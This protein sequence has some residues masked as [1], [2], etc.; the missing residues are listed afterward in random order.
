MKRFLIALGLLAWPLFGQLNVLSNSY[1]LYPSSFGANASAS[2]CTLNEVSANDQCAF[3]FRVPAT[4]DL[5][6]VGWRT[7]TV[8][9]SQSLTIRLETVDADTGEPTGTLYHANATV[10]RPSVVGSTEYDETYSAFTGTQGDVVALVIYFTSTA[11]NLGVTQGGT[12]RGSLAAMGYHIPKDAGAWGSKTYIA[13][14][15]S[16]TVAGI[17]YPL[18]WPG[19]NDGYTNSIT[20]FNSGSAQNEYGIRI[21]SAVMTAR[22]VG[23]MWYLYNTCAAGGNATA[24]LYNSVGTEIAASWAVDCDQTALP[25]RTFMRFTT[26]VIIQKGQQYDLTIKPGNTN[27]VGVNRMNFGS[28][29]RM[30]I[31]AEHGDSIYQ[32]TKGTGG[33]TDRAFRPAVYLVLDAVYAGS[34]GFVVTQ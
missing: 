22:A 34:G 17:A 2:S 16:I 14:W 3:V 10:A 13:G 31:H 1:V 18:V 29:A 25:A 21:T 27:S 33:T 7:G 9:V 32:V 15:Q 11:G 8:T 28:Q 12:I 6:G 24:R 23:A 5:T 30:A 26:P 19:Y 20:S 4:G